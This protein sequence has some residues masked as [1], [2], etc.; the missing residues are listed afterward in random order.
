[1]KRGKG[2]A[3]RLAFLLLGCRARLRWGRGLRR[4]KRAAPPLEFPGPL[5]G[6][7][8]GACSPLKNSPLWL[9]GNRRLWFLMQ[10][11]VGKGEAAIPGRAGWGGT[12]HVM[13]VGLLRDVGAIGWSGEVIAMS[14]RAA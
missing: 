4:P 11:A 5:R 12:L 10:A 3:G 7:L 13:V 1:M 8:K 14:P 6:R 9:C 2:E